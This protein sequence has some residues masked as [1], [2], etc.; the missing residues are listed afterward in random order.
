MADDERGDG[1]VYEEVVRFIHKDGVQ[2][3]LHD[4]ELVERTGLEE[5]AEVSARSI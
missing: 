4:A 1:F 3:A 5:E 2:A